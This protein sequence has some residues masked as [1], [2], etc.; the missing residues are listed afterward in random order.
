MW[1]WY[2]QEFCYNLK[3]FLPAFTW[4]DKKRQLYYENSCPFLFGIE[5]NY[6]RIQCFSGIF[7]TGLTEAWQEFL[8]LCIDSLDASK[9]PSMGKC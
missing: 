1:K 5:N 6:K 9:K 7:L 3:F 2:E 4:W 8:L